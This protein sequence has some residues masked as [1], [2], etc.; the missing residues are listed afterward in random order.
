MFQEFQ[1]NGGRPA[2]MACLTAY[3]NH[4][5]VNNKVTISGQAQRLSEKIRDRYRNR[6]KTALNTNLSPSYSYHGSTAIH[7]QHTPQA[8][9]TNVPRSI[10]RKPKNQNTTTQQQWPQS[11]LAQQ[12]KTTTNHIEVRTVMSNLSPDD[13]AKT[14]MTNVSRMVETLGSVVNAL[15]METANTNDTMKQ[16]MIQQ[17][18]TMNN[19]MMLMS[20]NEER[21][22]EVP[23][24]EIQ[25]TSTPTST[26]TNSQF[27]LSQQSTSA[28]KRKID[29]IVK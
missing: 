2:A 16:M 12:Q 1:Q 19:F 27:S 10:V 3:Q 26:I 5:L 7:E 24:R 20:R 25:Q 14:M 6:P 21:R 17:T 8:T 22:Q 11:P 29:G 13:S 28:N 15:A 18:A 23:I 4:P 9:A